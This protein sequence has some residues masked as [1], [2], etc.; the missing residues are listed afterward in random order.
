MEDA[1]LDALPPGSTT[2]VVVGT[3]LKTHLGTVGAFL[4]G[5][6]TIFLD[7]PE[8]MQIETPSEF[9]S[10]FLDH[11]A[12]FMQLMGIFYHESWGHSEHTKIFADRDF[13]DPTDSKVYYW[14]LFEEFRIE[15]H[16]IEANDDAAPY[17]EAAVLGSIF[18]TRFHLTSKEDDFDKISVAT[19]PLSMLFLGLGRVIGGSLYDEEIVPKVVDIVKKHFDPDVIDKTIDIFEAIL[20]I[21]DHDVSGFEM[22]ASELEKVLGPVEDYLPKSSAITE[23][24][25]EDLS[26]SGSSSGG[27]SHGPIAPDPFFE[28]DESSGKG[29]AASI[30]VDKSAE[31]VTIY[32]DEASSKSPGAKE[33]EISERVR[34]ALRALKVSSKANAPV[35]TLMPP[36]RLQTREA[37]QRSSYRAQGRKPPD[38]IK[39]FKEKSIDTSLAPAVRT[40][41][42]IDLSGSMNRQLPSIS[43][44]MW[45]AYK[46]LQAEG[47]LCMSIGFG[48]ESQV[49]WDIGEHPNQIEVFRCRDGSFE[50]IGDAMDLLFKRPIMYQRRKDSLAQVLIFSDLHFVEATHSEKFRLAAKQLK[51]E[52]GV[53][54]SA[55]SLDSLNKDNAAYCDVAQSYEGETEDNVLGFIEAQVRK[56]QSKV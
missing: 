36:G 12:H 18:N 47:N 54:I 53:V 43:A 27:S 41:C 45:A 25:L 24:E 9:D 4:P 38:N 17:L 8:I 49:L 5:V 3:D 23:D 42:M 39:P 55:L 35:P 32:F 44:A 51:E 21:D 48:A 46:G 22:A 52:H 11:Q 2:N 15:Y 40:T 20:D 30:T 56:L 31:F 37:M 7:A 29:R 10:T 13:K 19:N 16:A 6:D 33:L 26:S 50:S 14:T 28:D 1:F 34:M